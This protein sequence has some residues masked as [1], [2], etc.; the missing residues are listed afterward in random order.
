MRQRRRWKLSWCLLLVIPL[1]TASSL[2]DE[3]PRN[4]N[5]QKSLF[6][7]RMDY[8][9]WKPLGRGDPLKNDPTFDYVPPQ[10]DH[11]HYWMDP[12]P[13]PQ[14]NPT[15][16]HGK[17][18]EILLLGVSSKKPAITASDRRDTVYEPYTKYHQEKNYFHHN[19]RV[20]RPNFFPSMTSQ[21]IP[22]IMS[23]ANQILDGTVFSKNQEHRVPY[24]VL[25]PPPI[26]NKES[27]L[28]SEPIVT[29]P[30]TQRPFTP[31]QYYSSTPSGR[32]TV[33]ESNL[34][35]QS[36]SLVSQKEFEAVP[37][38]SWKLP[39]TTESVRHGYQELSPPKS[40][41]RIQFAPQNYS[42]KIL[43][44]SDSNH[45]INYVT[46]P[47]LDE[48][49]MTFKGHV[50]D[51][52]DIS[53]SYV[54]IEKPQ[55]QINHMGVEIDN[56]HPLPIIFPHAEHFGYN[57]QTI[58]DME[59][60][61]PPPVTQNPIFTRPTNPVASLL[62]K[63]H[64][65]HDL[66][67]TNYIGSSSSIQHTFVST[68][69]PEVL[70]AA[71]TLATT[72]SHTSTI[73]PEITTVMPT[74][75]ET[76]TTMQALTTDPIFKHYKQPAEPLRGP[77]YLIIQG[78]SKVKTYKP[79]KQINGIMVQESNEI[80]YS[81]DRKIDYNIKHLHGYDMKEDLIQ[82]SETIARQRQARTGNLQTLKHVVQTGLG[83]I[84]FEEGKLEMQRRSDVDLEETELEAGFEVGDQDVTSE[85]YYKGIVE[86]A[87][88]LKI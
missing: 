13:Q 54:K 61:K 20:A 16:E 75:T 52:N 44:A 71:P 38:I 87:R 72:I 19:Q 82:K 5:A 53:D 22:S 81:K 40:F 34:I 48:S 35:Y 18:T 83:A 26:E 23:V 85:K 25:M 39:S 41:I 46:P 37:S 7:P 21:I 63:E 68:P 9:Q 67:S 86:E 36:S 43:E 55:A 60:M 65:K 45:N 51:D 78:H 17:K 76:V 77:L 50:S 28:V 10:L 88:K 3:P 14:S 80:P 70:T 8:N 64:V 58:R 47:P 24:T 57:M 27:N 42:N 2:H 62:R 31:S 32:V 33:Q 59:T 56:M 79:A 15:N 11:V 49:K 66:E 73:A 84:D 6:S 30:M 12:E 1:A 69:Q 4:R 74:T 29:S